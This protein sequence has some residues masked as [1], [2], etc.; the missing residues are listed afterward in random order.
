M[1]ELESFP[2]GTLWSVRREPG[3]TLITA[4]RW[5]F[6]TWT[7]ALSGCSR[8]S[9]LFLLSSEGGLPCSAICEPSYCRYYD[10]E[11][12]WGD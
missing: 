7:N 4:L 5:N 1:A 3:D 10:G 11:K 6:P 12:S 2:L 8:L 9:C